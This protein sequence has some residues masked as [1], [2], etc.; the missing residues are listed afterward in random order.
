MPFTR[1]DFTRLTE[2]EIKEEVRKEMKY[3]T[4]DVSRYHYQIAVEL[5]NTYSFL[6][7]EWEHFPEKHFIKDRF[8]KKTISVELGK[9]DFPI[10]P[11]TTPTKKTCGLYLIGTTTFN[12]YTNKP[13]FWIKIGKSEDLEKRMKSYCTHSPSIW[14]IDFQ[15]VPKSKVDKIEKLYHALLSNI[16]INSAEHSKEWYE[17]SK[18]DYLTICNEKFDFFKF[19]LLT[20]VLEQLII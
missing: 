12:P 8:V 19:D 14:R 2:R 1:K 20:L 7:N 13:F 9:G 11:A 3:R 16:G 5:F 15:E 17:V 18:E 4:G 6:H 10:P